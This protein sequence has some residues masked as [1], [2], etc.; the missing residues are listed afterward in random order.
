MKPVAI[1]DVVSFFLERLDKDKRSAHFKDIFQTEELQVL[2]DL[3][4][5]LDAPESAWDKV[6]KAVLKKSNSRYENISYQRTLI[7]IS[8]HASTS[9]QERIVERL[10]R[11]GNL[12]D[13]VE[14]IVHQ[15]SRNPTRSELHAVCLQLSKQHVAGES[16]KWETL[17]SVAKKY[18]PD[19][20]E[21]LERSR[22]PTNT[23]RPKVHLHVV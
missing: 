15:I 13:A 14:I 12:S 5:H 16:A 23:G 21:Q 6:A 17:I 9:T 7:S 20:V 4:T 11:S 19:A 10:L 8:P 2:I 3:I 22:W 1:E 18:V